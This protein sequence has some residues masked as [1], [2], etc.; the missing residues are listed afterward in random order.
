MTYLATAEIAGGNNVKIVKNSIIDAMDVAIK[1]A[2]EHG[3]ASVHAA[4]AAGFCSDPLF[5]Y[6][7]EIIVRRTFDKTEMW[8]S[9][10]GKIVD[11][12]CNQ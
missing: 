5:I 2:R 12:S 11:S 10:Y 4:D 1:L 3:K 8:E 9:Q 6:E 7:R